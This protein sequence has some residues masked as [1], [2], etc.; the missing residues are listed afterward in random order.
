MKIPWEL[1]T[2]QCEEAKKKPGKCKRRNRMQRMLLRR[3]LHDRSRKIKR[4]KEIC[5]PE[6]S[7]KIKGEYII[8]RLFA[9][10]NLINPR[11]FCRRILITRLDK[12]RK[13]HVSG[14][15]AKLSHYGPR[16][17]K[18]AH[19]LLA[20]PHSYFGINYQ[21]KRNFRLKPR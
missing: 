5:A 12:N 21:E 2:I 17:V 20:Q 13:I 1:E 10:R 19:L 4:T 15:A 8:Q 3:F 14:L 7:R 9:S 6:T 11:N 16:A 18:L